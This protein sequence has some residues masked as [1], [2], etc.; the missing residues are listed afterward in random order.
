MWHTGNNW[1]RSFI[2]MI[3][4]LG[5][6]GTKTVTE[7]A[8]PQKMYTELLVILGNHLNHKPLVDTEWFKLHRRNQRRMR[9]QYLAELSIMAECS[10]EVL[11][12]GFICGLRIEVVQKQLLDDIDFALKKVFKIVRGMETTTQITPKTQL[13]CR[14]G[15]VYTT[16]ALELFPL[17]TTHCAHRCT[18]SLLVEEVMLLQMHRTIAAVE[19]HWSANTQKKVI[20][21]CIYTY[22]CTQ[23]YSQ[24]VGMSGALLSDQVDC[25]GY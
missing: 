9:C 25:C 7:S 2:W 10:M 17:Q 11:W 5:S 21:V 3:Y 12:D 22:I 14:A 20:H 6:I 15:E 13:L 1:Y 8:M 4:F 24:D 19:L 16:V 23:W 18:C